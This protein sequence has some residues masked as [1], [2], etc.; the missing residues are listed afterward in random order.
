VQQ[1]PLVLQQPQ[2]ARCLRQPLV[3]LVLVLLR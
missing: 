1:L 3:L 2:T